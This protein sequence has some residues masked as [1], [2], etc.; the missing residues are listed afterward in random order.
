MKI[1]KWIPQILLAIAFLGA[2]AMKLFTPYEEM[3]AQEQMAWAK[4]FSPAII[5]IIGVLEVLGALGLIL[6]MVLK[7]YPFLVPTAAIGLALTM[8]GAMIVHL[9][10]GEPIWTNLFL[11]A[12]CGL[13][14]WWR[15]DL[16]KR[17]E[18]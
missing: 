10:Q 6:P 4:D 5:K 16:F 3:I 1:V 2:G 14:V 7:K 8:I 13:V 18:G 17:S 11:L 9:N 15:K 12:L